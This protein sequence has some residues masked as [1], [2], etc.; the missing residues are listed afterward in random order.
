MTA[1]GRKPVLALLMRLLYAAALALPVLGAHAAVVFTTLHSFRVFPDVQNPSGLVQGR[2]GSFY[3]TTYYGG[4]NGG[5]TVFKISTNGALTNLYSFIG[6]DGAN[7]SAALVQ[8]NDGY[9][10]GTTYGGGTK[11][12]GT[13]FKISANGALTNL[14]SFT[15]NDGANPS[16]ALVQGSDGYLYG[17]T[18]NGGVTNNYGTVFKIS[19]DGHLTTLYSFG[20][21]QDTNGAPLD[22]ANPSAALVQGS[23]GYLYGTTARGGTSDAGSVFKITTNGV[24]TTL[25][26]FDGIDGLWPV[27]ALVQG[28]DGNFY[29]TTQ[30]GGTNGGGAGNVFKISPTGKLTNLYDFGSVQDTNNQSLDGRVPNGL[31]QDS[32]GYFYGTTVWG[33][34]SDAGSVFK[35]SANGALTSLHSFNGMDGSHPS[36]LVQGSD[37]YFYGTTSGGG[38][39]YGGTVFKISPTGALTTLYSFT[40]GNDGRAP[41]ALMQGT[42]G[43]FYGTTECIA[44]GLGGPF[45]VGRG[46]VF[47]I[48]TNGALTTLYVFGSITNASGVALD[49]ANPSAGPVQGYDGS[50]YGTTSAGGVGGAG[51]IFRLTIVPDPQ[52]SIIPSGPYVVLTWPTDYNGLSYAGFTLLATTN[53][54]SSVWSSISPSPVVIGGQNVVIT[55]IS[56]IQQF[57]RLAQ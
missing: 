19:P 13:V 46:T 10:Y 49:G 14:H 21:V 43:S 20:S 32:D 1:S 53:L 23:D 9:F 27:A 55:T 33:G 50:F 48:S 26:S 57:Y 29:G 42:D 37:G 5:G 17:T 4:T 2:D 45:R 36:G 18:Q 12:N 15:G 47:K 7:P 41:N 16:A 54:V 30:N 31:V 28:S 38:T 51:T 24:L 44:F 8:G 11:G 56:G 25:H 6:N 22:G 52:L 3:G 34:T 39:N 40:T 35:I